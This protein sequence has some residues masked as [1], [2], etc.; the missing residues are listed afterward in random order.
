MAQNISE[1]SWNYVLGCSTRFQANHQADPLG[2]SVAKSRICQHFERD[3]SDGCSVGICGTVSRIC[4]K[5]LAVFWRRMSTA[6]SMSSV[7]LDKLVGKI[8]FQNLRYARISLYSSNSHMNEH[9][10]LNNVILHYWSAVE[11]IWMGYR[12]GGCWG[13]SRVATMLGWLV[14]AVELVWPISPCH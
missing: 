5:W 6:W 12:I 2:S 10:M 11:V 4:N 14:F 1:I 9:T 8:C 7:K 13:I 3:S